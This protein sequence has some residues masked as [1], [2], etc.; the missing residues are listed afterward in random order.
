MAARLWILHKFT[1]NCV[2]ARQPTEENVRERRPMHCCMV[3][4]IATLRLGWQLPSPA[5]ISKEKQLSLQHVCP[6]RGSRS[7]PS[8][9]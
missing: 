1:Q 4:G 7:E 3:D 6:L 2:R 9:V 8:E 5:H